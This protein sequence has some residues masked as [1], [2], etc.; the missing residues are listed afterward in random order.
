VAS[1][2]TPQQ[3]SVNV[4][5]DGSARLGAL[6]YRVPEG[7]TVCIGD[8]V[9]VPFG[10]REAYGVVLGEGDSQKATREVLGVFGRRVHPADIATAAELAR[11]HLCSIEALVPR[12]AP[13]T[14]KGAEAVPAGDVQLK[15]PTQPQVEFQDIESTRRLAWCT[16]SVDRVRFAAEEAARFAEHGQVLVLCPTK[17]L[18]TKVLAQLPSG[19]AR[20]DASAARGAWSGFVEGVVPI[21]VGTRAAAL[22]SPKSLAG[23]V[24][25]DCE[26]PGHIEAAQPHTHARDVA[27]ERSLRHESRLTLVSGVCDPAA[28]PPGLKLMH[29]G[30][31]LAPSFIV[32]RA[33]IANGGKLVPTVIQLE[34]RKALAV[35]TV[36]LV[37]PSR[38]RLACKHCRATVVCAVG[39]HPT[40]CVCDLSPCERCKNVG[41]Q[42]SGWDA[43]RLAGVFSS[44]PH[45][46]RLVCVAPEHLNT[47]S[48][49]VLTV[50]LDADAPTKS[51]SLQP[52][53]AQ[54]R[55]LVEAASSLGDDGHLMIATQD[56]SSPLLQRWV[57]KDR[58]GVA[59]V[60]WRAAK[61]A[62]L[63]P[64]GRL[65]LVRVA[66]ATAPN[67]ATWPGRVH[68][69]RQLQ[70]GEWEILVR[71]SDAEL[72]KLAQ[73]LD[74]L[75]RSAKVRITVS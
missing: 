58:V 52:E 14:A 24:V 45:S 26:H 15:N 60:I 4:L 74:R 8:A 53:L 62:N 10:K 18:V 67:V 68:G 38:C 22:F 28:M 71:C 20:L 31:A 63:P 47:V 36:C 73:P 19:A 23:I 64:F 65:V 57:A 48:D 50:L 27:I 61:A 13:R 55:L 34:I 66:R 41:H 33:D 51:A 40:E 29:V 16:P 7:L 70:P 44:Y 30:G 75:R 72:P 6:S 42:P 21:A 39:H 43:K 1:S 5:V 9:H 11:R 2:S 25:L 32:D 59:R 12:F 49:A 69:P 17:E 54:L 35:G 56:A 3:S 37:A 46:E